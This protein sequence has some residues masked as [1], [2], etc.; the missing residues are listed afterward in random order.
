MTEG[1]LNSCLEISTFLF[2]V[3]LINHQKINLAKRQS[4]ILEKV[5]MNALKS[6]QDEFRSFNF[7]TL[8]N[9][10]KESKLLSNAKPLKF[11]EIHILLIICLRLLFARMIH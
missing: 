5:H 3:S 8:T 6:L 4:P 1:S 2:T 7:L 9:R 11:N 10:L